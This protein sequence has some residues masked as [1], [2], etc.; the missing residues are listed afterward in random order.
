MSEAPGRRGRFWSFLLRS[1]GFRSDESQAEDGPA[2]QPAT[3]EKRQTLAEDS[4]RRPKSDASPESPTRSPQDAEHAPRGTVFVGQQTLA[5]SKQATRGGSGGETKKP[6]YYGTL[7]GPSPTVPPTERPAEEL[8]LRPVSVQGRETPDPGESPS[9]ADAAPEPRVPMD[10]A[11][12]PATPA[13]AAPPVTPSMAM[14][15]RPPRPQVGIVDD[16]QQPAPWLSAHA[17]SRIEQDQPSLI[18]P[19][20]QE[21]QKTRLDYI[22]HRLRDTR[23]PLCPVNGVLVLLPLQTIQA[24]PREN[25]ELQR[26]V[27]ADLTTIQDQLQL[28]FPSTALIVGMEENKGF[29]E[30]VRRVGPQRAASQRFG[31]RFDVRCPATGNELASLCIRIAGVFEDW[32]YTIFRERGSVA[33]QGNTHLFGLLCKARTQLQGR[34]QQVLSGGFGHSVREGTDSES[35]PFSGCYFA[36]TGR[37]EDRQAFVRGVFDKLVEEQNDVEWTRLALATDRFLY[38]TGWAG[39]LVASALA[40]LL[41]VDMLFGLT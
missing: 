23:Q 35:A 25:I 1:V 29:E 33:R 14:P 30:L 9:P 22:C 2:E 21:E 27:K 12:P 4:S 36:A 18:P 3:P 24:G 40:G 6:A 31:H 11:V 41:L 7:V 15:V 10:T 17:T 13:P 34:L 16:L 39:L 38:L 28:R 37:T 32:I 20:E 5:D 8:E 19:A 26:A